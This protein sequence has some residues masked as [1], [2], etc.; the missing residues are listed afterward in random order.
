MTASTKAP[1]NPRANSRK[2][3]RLLPATAAVADMGGQALLIVPVSDFESWMEDQIDIAL[4]KQALAEK[5]PRIPM[6]EA[7][8]RLGIK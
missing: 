8:R 6:E 7:H 4:A 3:P 5:K 1:R 2:T